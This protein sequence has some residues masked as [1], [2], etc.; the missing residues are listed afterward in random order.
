MNTLISVSDPIA[1]A[2]GRPAP[3]VQNQLFLA[4]CALECCHD[5]RDFR[6]AG[7]AGS[8]LGGVVL[9]ITGSP[10]C[11]SIIEILHFDYANSI[12]R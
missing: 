5:R 7:G 1:Q 8:L 2:L 12:F 10:P 3:T 9:H 11:D 6:S 4:G